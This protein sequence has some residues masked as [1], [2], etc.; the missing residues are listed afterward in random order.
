MIEMNNM[1]N[2]YVYQSILKYISVTIVHLNMLW[3]KSKSYVTDMYKTTWLE[4][5]VI[6][7]TPGWP[8]SGFFRPLLRFATLWIFAV[9]SR[10]LFHTEEQNN[11]T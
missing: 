1:W 11:V 4:K 6:N 10:E 9:T 3:A 5:Q 2:I 7:I 8:F